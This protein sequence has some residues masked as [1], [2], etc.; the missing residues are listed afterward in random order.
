MSSSKPPFKPFNI[1]II[2]GGIAGLTLAIALLKHDIPIQLYEAAA[3][4]G[5]IGAGVAFG[6]NAARAMELIS[7][8]IHD[9]FRR[10]KTAN[11]SDR[12][13]DLWFSVR[14]GD[15]RCADSDGVVRRKGDVVTRVGDILFDC[16]YKNNASRGGVHR[17]HFLDALVKLIPDEVSR[18]GKKLTDIEKAD[19]GSGDVVLK[20]LDGSTARHGAVIGCD[21]IKS[22]TREIL[23]GKDNPAARAVFSGKYAYRGLIPMEK[24]VELLGEEE[25]KNSQFYF[26]YHGH[27]LTFPIEKGKTMNVVAFNSRETW[28]D[29]NWVVHATKEEMIKDFDGWGPTVHKIL[30]AVQKPD[31][32]ALFN[33]PPASTYF[34][35][36]VV[37]VGDAAHATTP[38]Q[39]SG[40]GMC[41][42]DAYIISNLI[43]EANSV[44]DLE[45]AF[46]AYDKS[47]RPRTQKLVTTS[48]EAGMLYDLELE[49]MIWTKSRRICC[50]EW[51]G[52]G[53][54]ACPKKWSRLWDTIVGRIARLRYRRDI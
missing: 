36:R 35:D 47:R 40:A 45:K 34:K 37:L 3:R 51:L 13:K 24:A 48:K 46:F 53:T 7:P 32:W 23:L 19:D 39:G 33:H 54:W 16:P 43:K 22:R 1:A 15:A 2:G 6:P 41:V 9:A 27:L 12:C 20:F 26:G 38:H 8:E 21:G 29:Q 5:E 31:I 52:Y 28:E 30:S 18:F 44:E 49:G 11:Q 17:A 14:I 50:V 10:C 42:E 25:A 4:F